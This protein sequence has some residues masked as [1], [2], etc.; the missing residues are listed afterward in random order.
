MRID[1]TKS[2]GQ[3]GNSEKEERAPL[4]AVTGAQ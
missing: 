3:I 2:L 4:E 1:L